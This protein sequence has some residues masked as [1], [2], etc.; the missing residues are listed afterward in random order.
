MW[1]LPEERELLY[2]FSFAGKQRFVEMNRLVLTSAS[3]EIHMEF[4]KA[5]LFHSILLPVGTQ[6]RLTLIHLN[7]ILPMRVSL[8][9]RL[10]ACLGST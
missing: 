7:L 5:S 8:L 3:L 2:S 4:S 1:P 6:V 9:R 10:M